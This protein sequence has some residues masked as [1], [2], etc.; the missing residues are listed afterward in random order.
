MNL[1]KQNV[2][3]IA[4]EAPKYIIILFVRYISIHPKQ[5]VLVKSIHNI[6]QRCAYDILPRIQISV[7]LAHILSHMIYTEA[8]D[9]G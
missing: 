7:V 9:I 5:I 3:C 2:W 8:L 4:A 1:N 6:H